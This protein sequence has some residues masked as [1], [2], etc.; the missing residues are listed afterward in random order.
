MLCCQAVWVR[1]Y[2][3]LKAVSR[4]VCDVSSTIGI[5]KN[6]LKYIKN[7]VILI[8]FEIS[9]RKNNFKVFLIKSTNVDVAIL[10][11]Y[12]IFITISFKIKILVARKKKFTN[13][14][15]HYP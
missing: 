13:I 8:I 10:S 15:K 9:T 3:F 2:E 4:Y 11:L 7:Q 1:R 6:K 5:I 12:V 14:F